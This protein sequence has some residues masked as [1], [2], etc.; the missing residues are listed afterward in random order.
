MLLTGGLA[1]ALGGIAV[2][3]CAGAALQAQFDAALRA[4]AQALTTLTEEDPS[5]VEID[6]SA[7]HMRSFEAGGSDYFELRLAEG[8]VVERSRSLG[9]RHLPFRHGALEEPVFWN[10]TLPDGQP[11]RA[12]GV[13]FRANLDD[14]PEGAQA[15]DAFLVPKQAWFFRSEAKKSSKCASVLGLLVVL[16]KTTTQLQRHFE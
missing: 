11:G 3:L 13:Q 8:K 6:S 15:S 10:L 9:D 12:A 14:M 5:G 7:E 2:Y 4:K 1:I 16:T